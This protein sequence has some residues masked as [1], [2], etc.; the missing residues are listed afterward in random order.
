MLKIDGKKWLD[1]QQVKVS[2]FTSQ[3]KHEAFGGDLVK[4]K[5]L[6]NLPDPPSPVGYYL[7]MCKSKT[8][9][10]L[11]ASKMQMIENLYH[12]PNKCK[13]FGG[14]PKFCEMYP[15][16]GTTAFHVLHI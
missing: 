8:G 1:S 14:V 10:K 4:S 13:K 2:W 9:S 3:L 5:L 6:R 7:F 16:V 11:F 15:A 12:H